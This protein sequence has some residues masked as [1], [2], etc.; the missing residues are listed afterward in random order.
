MQTWIRNNG[1]LN[2]MQ[3]ETVAEL[4][5]GINKDIYKTWGYSRRE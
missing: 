4:V 1:T 2:E 5:V 3:K